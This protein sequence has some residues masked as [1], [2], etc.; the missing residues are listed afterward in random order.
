ML[1]TAAGLVKL[2]DFGG[3]HSIFEA[4]SQD[5]SLGTYYHAAPEIIQDGHQRK[6]LPTLLQDLMF[7]HLVLLSL[8]LHTWSF[9]FWILDGIVLT[10][11]A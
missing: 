4:R 2:C 6:D 8:N 7:G 1:V 3:A 10:S 11:T 5:A 9:L